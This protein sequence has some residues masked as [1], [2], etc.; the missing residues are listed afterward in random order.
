MKMAAQDGDAAIELNCLRVS[1]TIHADWIYEKVR[2]K[3]SWGA[4]LN[5]PGPR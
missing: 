2:V 3:I 5:G 4:G 1:V